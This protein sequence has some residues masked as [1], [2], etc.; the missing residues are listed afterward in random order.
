M[1][2]GGVLA[3]PVGVV[4]EPR[5]GAAGADGHRERIQGQ[6]RAQV[7]GQRPADDAARMRVE[8]HREVQPTFGC[9]EIGDVPD[10]QTIG[11]GGG[12]VARH[13]IRRGRARRVGDRGTDPTAAVATGQPRTPQQARNASA[14]RADTRRL[15]HGME[16]RRTVRAPAP[17]VRR[18]D[19]GGQCLVSPDAR[20]DPAARPGVVGRARDPQHAAQHDD[21][22][23]RPLRVDEP[24]PVH[25]VSFAK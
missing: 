5:A 8:E 24:I 6:F 16:P 19:L 11:G 12:E 4:D 17:R 18:R 25:R 21:R 7:V 10:P 23:V 20:R 1:N 9:G 14:R 3:A 13:E 22:R 2:G 15:Q